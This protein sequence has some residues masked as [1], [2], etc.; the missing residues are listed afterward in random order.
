MRNL[1]LV[2]LVVVS[3][4]AY[5]QSSP[6]KS[7]K[8]AS[9]KNEVGDSFVN[10]KTYKSVNNSER[11]LFIENNDEDQLKAEQV[12]SVVLLTLQNAKIEEDAKIER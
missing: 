3:F 5:G 1:A 11:N 4:S 12:L 10:N 8:S 6:S 7:M 2:M 9:L